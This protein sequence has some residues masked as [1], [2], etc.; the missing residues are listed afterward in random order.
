MNGAT[1]LW[2]MVPAVYSALFVVSA[3]RFRF[4]RHGQ[5]NTLIAMAVIAV[6]FQALQLGQM[7]AAMSVLLLGGLVMLLRS[8]YDIRRQR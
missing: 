4:W 3:I 2:N 6:S 5:K 7:E 8:I 1:I